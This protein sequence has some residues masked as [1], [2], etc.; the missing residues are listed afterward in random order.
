MYSM[1]RWVD[2][3]EKGGPGGGGREAGRHT[4]PPHTPPKPQYHHTLHDHQ[5]TKAPHTT[6]PAHQRPTCSLDSSSTYSTGNRSALVELSWPTWTG[7]PGEAGGRGGK[8]WTTCMH[9]RTHTITRTYMHAHIHTCGP[10]AGIHTHACPQ[11]G[12]CARPQACA[13]TLMW[14]TCTHSRTLTHTH[15]HARTCMH[16]CTHTQT[17]TC[18][19]HA[20]T[21]M[22]AHSHSLANICTVTYIH[23]HA[24]PHAGMCAHLNESGSEVQHAVQ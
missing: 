23:T 1:I 16:A 17:H 3:R 18:G 4:R 24:C 13:P 8:M 12:M 6:T 14:T 21:C 11:A 22:H 15:S 19:P 20:R 10:H 2:F 5:L 9:S 7:M